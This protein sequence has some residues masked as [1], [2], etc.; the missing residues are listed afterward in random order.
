M[1]KMFRLY[2]RRFALSKYNRRHTIQQAVIPFA[3]VL[4]FGLCGCMGSI[5]CYD[6]LRSEVPIRMFDRYEMEVIGYEGRGAGFVLRCRPYFL[7]AVPSGSSI[8]DIPILIIDT[9]CFFGECLKSPVCLGMRNWEDQILGYPESLGQ[10]LY[11]EPLPGNDLWVRN[12]VIVPA[13][14]YIQSVP[15]F[16]KAC[17]GP[18]LTAEIR[19]RLL[20]RATGREIARE[21]KSV[22]FEI[23][24][25]PVS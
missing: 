18:T 10:S 12:G 20:D 17:Y 9:V 5:R 22:K 2:H 16:A 15:Y 11:A 25:E 4:L 19:A 6:P 14:Y 8:S 23:R 24:R 3:I 21:S 1:R 13:G 7:S